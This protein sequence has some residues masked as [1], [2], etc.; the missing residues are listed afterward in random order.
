MS[1]IGTA[2]PLYYTVPQVP[3]P[4]EGRQTCQATVAYIP[5]YTGHIPGASSDCGR[6]TGILDAHNRLAH[7]PTPTSNTIRRY[8]DM[9]AMTKQRRCWA[10]K[11]HLCHF[12]A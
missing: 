4:R 11:D 7:P 2:V 6:R 3:P 9:C 8:Q 5:G 12:H 10:D 1:G